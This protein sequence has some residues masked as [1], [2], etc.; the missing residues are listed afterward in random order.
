[1]RLEGGLPGQREWFKHALYA[2][3]FYTG[4]GVKTIPGVREAIE[5]D[6]WT[7]AKEQ[8]G[9]VRGVFDRVAARVRDAEAALRYLQSRG[10][11]DPARIVYFGRSLGVAVATELAVRHRPYGLILESGFPSIEYMSE[12]VRPWLPSWV[13]HRI[14]AARYDSGSKIGGLDVPVLI[15]HGDAD[16][17]V[18]LH[19][20]QA[21]FEAAREPKSFYVVEGADHDNVSEVGGR[22]H[23]ERLRE[24]IEGLG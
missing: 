19:A 20:G 5:Q 16:E 23:I 6:D 22:A 15:V 2:P 1:M 12:I 4:Y 10:D 14:I 18:P 8:V 21:L 11:V 7:T 24:Y 3:G 17:T 9:V 13:V